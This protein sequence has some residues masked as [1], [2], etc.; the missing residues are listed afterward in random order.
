[1]FDAVYLAAAEVLHDQAGRKAIVLISDGVDVGSKVAAEQ[2]IE[3][4]QRADAVIYSVFYSDEEGYQMRAGG[5]PGAGAGGWRPNGEYA[6]ESL[7]KQTGGR[8][9]KLS[10]ELTL[11][12]VFEQIEDE[13]RNQYSI[14]YTPT[15]AT[16]S[17][18]FRRISLTGRND[19]LKVYTRAGYYPQD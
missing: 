15:N 1:M 4:A 10:G 16:G 5:R 13:L 17:S 2:A 9:Y 11:A 12:G 19:K 3:A 6:L 8:L 18:A 14:G 7:C